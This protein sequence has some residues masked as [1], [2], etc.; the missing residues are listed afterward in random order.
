[1]RPV[2]LDPRHIAAASQALTGELTPQSFMPLAGRSLPWSA[3]GMKAILGNCSP[4]PPREDDRTTGHGRPPGAAHYEPSA[5]VVLPA[6]TAPA[7]TAMRA[8]PT[9][10]RNVPGI[11]PSGDEAWNA[12]RFSFPGGSGW[13]PNGWLPCLRRAVYRPLAFLACLGSIGRSSTKSEEVLAKD[14]PIDRGAAQ[15]VIGEKGPPLAERPL[16]VRPQRISCA[17][18]TLAA[19]G[20][21]LGKSGC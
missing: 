7:R 21:T 12:G 8:L 1:M 17:S 13:A 19:C 10:P 16:A 5:M 2:Y 15:A 3:G 20:R 11:G 9:A 6:L 14:R 18:G 4:V